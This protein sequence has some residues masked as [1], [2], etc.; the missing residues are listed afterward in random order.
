MA[1]KNLVKRSGTFICSYVYETCE[2]KLSR[3]TIL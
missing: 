2:S 1:D 3:D